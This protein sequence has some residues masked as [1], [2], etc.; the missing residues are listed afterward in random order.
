MYSHL[1]MEMR[2]GDR[3]R[4]AHPHEDAMCGVPQVLEHHI[5][6]GDSLGFPSSTVRIRGK[7]KRT[8]VLFSHNGGL[9]VDHVPAKYTI[10]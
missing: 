3:R 4:Q 9:E 5:W 8:E 10:K 7:V 6:D 1:E 2:E